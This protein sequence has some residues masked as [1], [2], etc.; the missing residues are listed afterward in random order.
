MMN[1]KYAR[2]VISGIFVLLLMVPYGI[3]KMAQL[4]EPGIGSDREEA[5]DRYGFFLEDV[6]EEAG[7]DFVHK[8]ATP[9]EKLNHI[10]PQISSVGASV[11]V[12]DFNND[13][14]SEE[15]TAELQ[16]RGQL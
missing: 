12:A 13:G 7:I 4:E 8:R 5:L 9:D 1:Q 10:L 14:R 6:T 3:R 2:A 16:S 15:H 11:S